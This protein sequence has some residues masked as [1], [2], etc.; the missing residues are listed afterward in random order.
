MLEDHRTERYTFGLIRIVEKCWNK[1][2]DSAFISHRTLWSELVFFVIVILIKI[3]NLEKVE[4]LSD[5][6]V[7]HLLSIFRINLTTQVRQ[8][9]VPAGKH[10][11]ISV[12]QPRGQL[13]A[14]RAR[15]VTQ[16][17]SSPRELRLW[18][19]CDVVQVRSKTR[20]GENC[21]DRDKSETSNDG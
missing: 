15:P 9:D 11:L 12:K 13:V 6:S 3:Y 10:A 5:R 1:V 21:M 17:E 7:Q 18:K 8:H 4:N 16:A 14:I 20:N 2:Y 19:D